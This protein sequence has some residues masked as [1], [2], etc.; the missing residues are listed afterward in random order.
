MNNH[1]SDIA[2]HLRA[3]ETET[4][5]ATYLQAQHLDRE[6]LLAVADAL[7]LTRVDRLSLK[8]LK[9]RI[10]NQAIGARRKSEGLRNW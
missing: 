9:E 1:P 3:T 10:L 6:G 4:E 5:G 2:A 7:G 8:G